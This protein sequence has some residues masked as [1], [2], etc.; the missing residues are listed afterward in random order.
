[1]GDAGGSVVG[2]V[3]VQGPRGGVRVRD[4]PAGDGDGDEGFRVRWSGR[5]PSC[6]SYP[7]RA[8]AWTTASDQVRW[9]PAAARSPGPRDPAV[10]CG[11]RLD[12]FGAERVE[13][14]DFVEAVEE[15]LEEAGDFA[16][17]VRFAGIREAHAA[18]GF[19]AEVG[20]QDDDGAAEPG[21]AAEAVGEAAFVEEAEEDVE[22][23]WG[24]LFD[25]VE[26][27]NTEGLAAD[28]FDPGRGTALGIEEQASRGTPSAVLAHVEADEAVLLLAGA[29]AEV[30][31]GACDGGFSDTGRAA[32]E[33]DAEGPAGTVQAGL[34]GGDEAG[35]GFSGGGL[36]DDLGG[37]PAGKFAGIEREVIP[38]E[39]FGKAGIADEGGD[40]VGIGQFDRAVGGA[41]WNDD[42]T[43]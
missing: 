5:A 18:G 20:G 23:L 43:R 29:E 39:E 12:V 22:D 40:G 8:T 27:D 1:M 17:V 28:A 15:R 24:G 2:A 41:S 7:A 31:E 36:A 14:D 33:E 32:E 13:G 9:R 42:G 10:P 26:E 34:D 4:T 35:S 30:D 25:L 38:E 21:D 6:R 19:G 37:E 3:E 16:G 11:D